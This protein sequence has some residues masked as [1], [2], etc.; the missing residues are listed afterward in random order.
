[1]QNVLE[2]ECRLTIIKINF[3]KICHTGFESCK[4]EL[5]K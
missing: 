3:D 1:M 2:N 4:N 5:V